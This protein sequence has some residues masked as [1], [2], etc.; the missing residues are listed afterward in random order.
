MAT[1]TLD[2]G[3]ERRTRSTPNNRRLVR[4]GAL[5]SVGAAAATVLF[6]LVLEAIDVPLEVDGDEIPIPGFAFATLVGS[7]VG[8]LLAL[9]F[10][11]WARRPARTFAITTVALGLA[12]FVPVLTADADT[13]TQVGLALSH[14]VAAAVVIP[15]LAVALAHR[16]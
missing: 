12:S 8:I 10:A 14:V 13:A 2:R 6:A 5:A 1:T 3:T 4:T 7:V 11:R 16:E 15:A 9:A